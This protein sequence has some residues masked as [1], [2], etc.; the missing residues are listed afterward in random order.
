MK[1]A[2]WGILLGAILSL[3]NIGASAGEPLCPIR[4]W[5]DPRQDARCVVL[6]SLILGGGTVQSGI[7]YLGA[8]ATR[9][10]RGVQLGFI[11]QWVGPSWAFLS[12]GETLTFLVDGKEI[13]L[14][15]TGSDGRRNITDT[16]AATET[17]F[18]GASPETLDQII[19]AKRVLIEI[20]GET[21]TQ[22]AALD[23]GDLACLRAFHDTAHGA[24]MVGAK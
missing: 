20:K 4:E 9:D 6:D 15:C 23:T 12:P 8:S 11:V 21:L 5:K 3:I 2:R 10:R 24:V 14:S 1:G 17:T 13:P 16:G 19:S 7:W 22:R 18:C